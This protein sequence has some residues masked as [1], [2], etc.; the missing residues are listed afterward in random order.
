ASVDEVLTVIVEDAVLGAA[1]LALLL[2]FLH[3]SFAG[4]GLSGLVH[5]VVPT[6]QPTSSNVR[7]LVVLNLI[8]VLYFLPSVEMDE[9]RHTIVH[10]SI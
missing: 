3:D 10:A 1:F 4:E 8:I 2:C 7:N 6:H 9:V 5:G